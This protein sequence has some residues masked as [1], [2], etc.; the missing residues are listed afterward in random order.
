VTNAMTRFQLYPENQRFYRDFKMLALQWL[1]CPAHHYPD[2]KCACNSPGKSKGLS[3]PANIDHHFLI[4]SK[5]EGLAKRIK[6]N[7]MSSQNGK[8]K[9]SN[10][11]SVIKQKLLK[12]NLINDMP[13]SL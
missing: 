13:Y 9:K 5:V 3:A 10:L 8:K 4:Y 12:S 2:K 6:A 1:R 11:P 7:G